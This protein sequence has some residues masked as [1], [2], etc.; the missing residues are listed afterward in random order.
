M[1]YSKRHSI[2]TRIILSVAIQTSAL[3]FLLGLVI[4]SR[5]KPLNEGSFTEKLSTTMRLTDSTLSAFLSSLTSDSIML[6][7]LY[8][9]DDNE[10]T[11]NELSEM[12]V[13]GAD[14]LIAGAIATSDGRIL[15]FPEGR[16]SFEDV[17]N[18]EWYQNVVDT[19]DYP[20]FSPVYENE[21]GKVAGIAAH[22]ILNDQGETIAVSFVEYDTMAL[23]VLIGDE[24]SMGDIKFYI[25]DSETNL[26]LDPFDVDHVFK[27]AAQT[28]LTTLQSY[29]QGDYKI[30]REEFHGETY[31]IRI[32]P[33]ENDYFALDYAMLIPIDTMNASTDA[34]FQTIVFAII[35]GIGISILI[36]FILARAITKA[37]KKLIAI[38]KNISEGN[39]DLTVRIPVDSK[40][41]LGQLA[42]YFNLTIEKI[43]NSLKS[44]I[45]ESSMMASKGKELSANMTFSA[46]S[47]SDINNSVSGI[48]DDIVNQSAGVEQTNVTLNEIAKNIEKLNTNIINQA[49]SVTQ[50]SAAVEEMVANIASV[51]KILEKNQENVVQLAESAE[52][53]KQLIAKTVEMTNRI[54]DDSEGLL[55]TSAI[56]QN[57]AEQTNLLAMNAAIEAAHAGESGKGFAVVADEIRKL[58]EDSNAQGKKISDVLVHLREMI[59]TMTKDAQEM[60]NQFDAIFENTQTVKQQEGV[61]KQAMDEQTAGSNQIL[62]AMHLINT[63]TT[64]VRNSSTIMEE[65]SKEIL[66]EMEK[67]S[68]ATVKINGAMMSIASGVTNL[69]KTMQDVNKVSDDTNQSIGHVSE[70]ISKFKVD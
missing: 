52:E 63:I 35:G 17:E 38:L 66:I 43:A 65:G 39:G 46:N 13:N 27:N 59:V 47:I 61:I 64:D 21:D 58:A 70:E 26:V 48:K 56:I 37:L 49:E 44:I 40:D 55:E 60:Q 18:A 67:L 51:T 11:V 54:S 7:D 2:S 36:A 34:I 41:E 62:D 23:S 10:E 16:F 8:L 30:A 45:F 6:G 4:Y 22:A 32:L 42:T 33:S 12:I 24:T 50:S 20:F 1:K 25:L 69:N 5:I 31:E 14:Y 3:L 29:M 68:K 53:G 19:P 28:D 9:N 57:I 15:G